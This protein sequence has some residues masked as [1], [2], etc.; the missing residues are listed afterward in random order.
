MSSLLQLLLVLFFATTRLGASPFTLPPSESWQLPNGLTV[1]LLPQEE[2]PLIHVALASRGGSVRDGQ[3]FGLAS[4]TAESLWLG[5][6]RLTKDTWEDLLDFHGAQADQIIQ[7]DYSLHEMSLASQDL[8]TLLPLFAQL[9]TQANF[10]EQE[11]KKLRSRRISELQVIKESPS[12]LADGF[13]RRFLFGNHP[14]GSP[15]NGTTASIKGITRAK[16]NDFYKTWYQPQLSTLVIAGKFDRAKVKDLISKV[17]SPWRQISQP[18]LAIEAFTPPSNARLRILLV[19]KPDAIETTIRIGSPAIP[20]NHPDWLPLQLANT[21]IGGRFTSQLNQ[22]LR[23]NSGLTYGAKSSFTGFESFGLFSIATF[24]AKE[25]SKKTIELA[26]QVYRA[27][28]EQGIEESNLLGAKSYLNGLL[29]PRFETID[30]L[31]EHLVHAWSYRFAANDLNE[32][33]NSISATQLVDLNKL[34]QKHLAS[35]PLS[36]VLIGDS[37]HLAPLAKNWGEVQSISLDT[38]EKGPWPQW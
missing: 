12:Q 16:I 33:Q 28:L 10:P 25:N 1:T 34:I 26:L 3:T 13:F 15:Q 35:Q 38:M 8:D 9:I 18:S 4:L 22:A 14:Y 31:A 5:S 32:F 36:L 7:N 6:S 21:V 17:F 19:D 23:I 24:T 37:K 27:F 20:R 29:P 2:V 11:I 30:K